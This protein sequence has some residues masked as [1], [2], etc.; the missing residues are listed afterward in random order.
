M[1]KLE[2]VAMLIESIEKGLDAARVA[3]DKGDAV[4][5]KAMI[6]MTAQ[7]ASSIRALLAK[8]EKAPAGK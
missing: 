5:A 6:G 3:L 8:V 7:T 1:A 2:A 4:T